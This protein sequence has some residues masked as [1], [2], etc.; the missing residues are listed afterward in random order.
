[1]IKINCELCGKV[2]ERLNRALIEGVEL[3]VCA[4]CSKFGK[5]LAPVKRYS[6]KEQHS[7]AKASEEKEEKIELLVENYADIIKKM[8]ESMGLSQKDFASSIN[9]KESTLHKIET[10]NLYPDLSLAKKLEKTLRV[11]LIE[12]HEERRESIKKNKEDGFTLGDFI[13]IKK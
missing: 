3:N 10:G 8:R 9:E 12:E 6:P 4:G 13:K 11:K 7:M 2:D 1:M 5:I